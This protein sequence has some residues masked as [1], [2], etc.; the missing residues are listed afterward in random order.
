MPKDSHLYA[1]DRDPAALARISETLGD[2]PGLTLVHSS[3]G[4]LADVLRERN[5]AAADAA[6]FDLGM[7]SDQLSDGSR[8]F[9]YRE[10]GPL[11]MRFDPGSGT[12][13]KELVNNLDQNDLADLIFKLGGERRSRR[14]ARRIVQ[15]RPIVNTSELVSAVSSAV[16]GYRPGVLSRVFQALRIAVN[17]E[18]GQLDDLL[19]SAEGWLAPGGRVAFITFHSLEDR[20]VKRFLRDDPGFSPGEP[21]WSA[22]SKEERSRNVRSRSAKLR[23]GVRL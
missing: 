6:V 23:R 11:D 19:A 12:S 15:R 20:R 10:D 3:F 4:R 5:A 16:R 13:A 1:L 7:S 21:E 9:S 8:G 2:H 18:M 17:D 14:I 22:P